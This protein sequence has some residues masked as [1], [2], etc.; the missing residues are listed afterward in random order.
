MA[1]AAG[2][3]YQM[4]VQGTILGETVAN[5]WY[6]QVASI[7]A[8]GI[9]A[10]NLAEGWWNHIKTSYRAVAVTNHTTAYQN[11]L[12]E[13]CGTGTREFGVYPVP[14]AEQGGTRSNGSGGGAESLPSFTAI[15]MRLNVGSRLTRPGQKRLW[16]LAEIDQNANQLQ[17]S[18]YGAADALGMTMRGTLTL[19]APA[20]LV[21]VF[22]VI[23]KTAPLD[24]VSVVQPI[25]TTSVSRTVR[26]QVSR[27]PRP[28]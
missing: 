10:T 17:A 26:S 19:G 27:R 15:G 12:A 9:D 8:G 24:H 16:G 28:F 13:Q 5:V 4:T 18:A 14:I 6:L 7:G 21:D 23:R 20:A 3:I 22:H 11:I 1:I 2:D 25:T